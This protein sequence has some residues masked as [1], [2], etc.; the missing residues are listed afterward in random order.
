MVRETIRSNPGLSPVTAR[1]LKRN[2]KFDVRDALESTS[3]KDS[4]ERDKHAYHVF[5]LLDN[6]TTK[7]YFTDPFNLNNSREAKMVLQLITL[8]KQ[9][10]PT[11]SLC[12]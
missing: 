6:E 12:L 8:D 3:G 2:S 5:D 1:T 4:E 11:E 10:G 7:I 9:K